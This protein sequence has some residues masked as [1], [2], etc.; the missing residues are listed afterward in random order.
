VVDVSWVLAFAGLVALVQAVAWLSAASKERV[1][2]R[3]R[4]GMLL[5]PLGVMMLGLGLLGALVP[6]FWG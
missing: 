3:A 2:L 6:G 4:V 1:H 5:A